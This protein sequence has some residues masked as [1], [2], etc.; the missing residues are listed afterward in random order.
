MERAS[1]AAYDLPRTRTLVIAALAAAMGMA[2]HAQEYPTKPIKLIVPFAPGGNADVV[3]RMAAS[4]MQEA[5]GSA[6]V[7]VEN[8]GGAGG[9]VGTG[10]AAKSEGDGYTLCAC[11]IGA[12]SIA[13]ATQKLRY[14][15]LS[16][17]VPISLLSTNPLILLV[18]PSVKARSVQELVALARR[19]HTR[20]PTVRPG[21]GGL[22][23]FSSELFQ[24]KTGIKLTHVPYRGGAPAT[25]AV[26][27]GDVQLTFANMSDAVGQIAAGT[28][29]PLGVTTAH[30]SAVA[31][32]VPTLAEQG[33][34]GYATE[35][36]IGLF[37][38]KGTPR[39]IVDRL[40][41]SPRA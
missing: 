29:R 7:V 13:S 3:A 41:G 30:R 8:H 35:F 11:S 12:I 27:A 21:V 25:M 4:F 31:P 19:N 2:A 18:H 26:V 37:A 14:D 10:L 33:I 22:T 23:Y 20:S 39:A 32:D 36:W 1:H 15:P 24:V 5:L 28:V 17:L 40:A 34:A 9:I 16:D 38:P 6:S